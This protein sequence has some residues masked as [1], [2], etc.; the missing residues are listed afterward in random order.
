VANQVGERPNSM[1][2]ERA[3]ENEDGRRYVN[4]P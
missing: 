1:P 2:I 3:L 4:F